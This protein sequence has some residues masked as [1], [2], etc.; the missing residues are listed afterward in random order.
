[1]RRL[2]TDLQA[3]D[4][5]VAVIKAV[6]DAGKSQ[7][8]EMRRTGKLGEEQRFFYPEPATLKFESVGGLIL[9]EDTAKL[10]RPV[11]V[12]R[13]KELLRKSTELNEKLLELEEAEKRFH[14]AK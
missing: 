5:A 7:E 8:A 1:M 14:Y 3:L 12:R 6:S 10:M 4:E 13:T 2:M 9:D 11:L